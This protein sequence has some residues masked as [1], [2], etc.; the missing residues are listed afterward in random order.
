MVKPGG[1]AKG[2]ATARTSGAPGPTGRAKGTPGGGPSAPPGAAAVEA[3]L[4]GFSGEPLARLR[5]VRAAIRRLAPAAEERMAYGI[6]TFTLGG[7]LVH[8]AAFARHLGFYPGASGIAAFEA[9][10]AP[11]VHAKGSVQFPFDRPLPLRLIE[12]MVRFRVAE[13]LARPPRRRRAG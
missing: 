11:F 6:P 2:A 9:D 3:Y 4:E 13:N 5:R 12:R 1:K 7:N 10:L 8:Y